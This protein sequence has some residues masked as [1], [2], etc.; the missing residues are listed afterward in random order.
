MRYIHAKMNPPQR[1]P[2]TAD[3]K[4]ERVTEWLDNSTKK[5]LRAENGLYRNQDLISQLNA[6]GRSLGAV[7]C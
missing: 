4:R 7:D 2:M 6:I 1:Y 3:R 5:A